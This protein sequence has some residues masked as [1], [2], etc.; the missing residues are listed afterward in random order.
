[1][2]CFKSC[3]TGTFIDCSYFSYFCVFE[4]MDVGINL[5]VAEQ[6]YQSYYILV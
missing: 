5:C 4:F 6:C 1:M 3:A 2:S